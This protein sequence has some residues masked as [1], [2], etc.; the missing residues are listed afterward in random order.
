MQDQEYHYSDDQR[1]WQEAR[2][3]YDSRPG[4][5]ACEWYA[6]RAREW[7]ELGPDGW[8][9][10]RVDSLVSALGARS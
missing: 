7:R 3:D 9:E 4:E 8:I 1:Q 2:A 10:R 5:S 6:R